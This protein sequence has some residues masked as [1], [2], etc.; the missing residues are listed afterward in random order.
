M[1]KLASLS[2]WLI[3]KMSQF[4]KDCKVLLLLLWL[5]GEKSLKLP[6]WP[7]QKCIFRKFNVATC[8]CSMWR[9]KCWIVVW[10]GW[11]SLT[12]F[13]DQAVRLDNLRN[14]MFGVQW[15]LKIYG[16]KCSL[17]GE[18][19]WQLAPLLGIRG[20][21][22]SARVNMAASYVRSCFRGAIWLQDSRSGGW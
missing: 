13:I 2:V 9:S 12:W 19:W 1:N 20:G 15:K 11:I 10:P 7:S 18:E 16:P 5:H 8:M 14:R 22:N 17:S 21:G 3:V 6:C 4:A